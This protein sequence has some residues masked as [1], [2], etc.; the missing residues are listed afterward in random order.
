MSYVHSLTVPTLSHEYKDR[1]ACWEA[2]LEPVH[3]DAKGEPFVADDDVVV[4]P[5][6]EPNLYPNP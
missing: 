6:G 2:T 5:R 1:F 4:G 3:L